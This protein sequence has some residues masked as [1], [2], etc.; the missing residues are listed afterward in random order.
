MGGQAMITTLSWLPTIEK[1]ADDV[2][3]LCYGC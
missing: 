2:A 3:G 1:A